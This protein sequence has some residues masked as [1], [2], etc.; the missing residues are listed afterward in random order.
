MPGIYGHFKGPDLCLLPCML[1]FCTS[2]TLPVFMTFILYFC[3]F[4]VIL[5]I[6]IPAYRFAST[7]ERV[8]L[9]RTTGLYLFY[10]GTRGFASIK[11]FI[12]IFPFLHFGH[13]IGLFP[14]V[15]FKTSIAVNPFN[16]IGGG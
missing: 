10:N 16:S 3:F 12:T 7:W 6:L 5:G 11:A 13:S 1:F 4:S 9:Q 8:L 14:V 2:N 15:I